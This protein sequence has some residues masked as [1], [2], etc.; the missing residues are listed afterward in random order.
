MGIVKSLISALV[1]AM[2]LSNLVMVGT[3]HAQALTKP[4]KPDFT[5]DIQNETV[6]FTIE[7]QPFDANNSYNYSFF[8]DVQIS[9][10]DGSWSSFYTAKGDY[11]TQS[12]SSQTI[13]YYAIGESACF[14][15]VATLDGVAV[16]ANGQV[17]FQ[18]IAMIGYWGDGT[19]ANNV[20]SYG[21]V[22]KVSGWSDSQ[23]IILP[24]NTN[25]S[26][27]V[28]PTGETGTSYK[29]ILFTPNSQTAYTNRLQLAFN[30]KWSYV[31]MPMGGELEGEYEYSIDD[32]PFVSIVPN[33]TLNDR[34]AGGTTFV[35]NPSFSY[36]LDT[37]NLTNGD[38]EIV[39]RARFY[40]GFLGLRLD[41]SSRP[42]P[43]SLEG[44]TPLTTTSPPD[45]N[46]APNPT[47]T[48]TTTQTTAV[49]LEATITTEPFP[50]SVLVALIGPTAVTIIWVIHIKKRPKRKKTT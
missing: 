47:E 44:Q 9:T 6:V 2:I 5:V 32:A 34:Y 7:N 43:F 50:T 20:T 17:K 15:G 26:Y 25:P 1:L 27:Y 23:T 4:A 40:Y 35:Y 46:S 12:N 39:I 8:Y 19:Y 31:A 18:V 38:H 30:L 21:L 14:P 10:L 29:I 48:T 41:A 13:L 3:V 33:Q 11:P 42:F 24:S 36:L 37:S 49:S 22:G 45:I 16:P 28:S